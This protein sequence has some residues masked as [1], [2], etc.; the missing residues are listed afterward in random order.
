MIRNEWILKSF[1]KKLS[2]FNLFFLERLWRLAQDDEETFAKKKAVRGPVQA[3]GFHENLWKTH[4]KRVRTVCFLHC[5]PRP[6]RR[7]C[8]TWIRASGSSRDPQGSKA[9]PSGWVSRSPGLK[10]LEFIARSEAD[11]LRH[12]E[13][14]ASKEPWKRGFKQILTPSKTIHITLIAVRLCRY[15]DIFCVFCSKRTLLRSI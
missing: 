11:P 1:L 4:E 9:Y 10:S 6:S 14:R 8:R 12:R 7:R 2:L 3:H 15:F 5:A 13:I